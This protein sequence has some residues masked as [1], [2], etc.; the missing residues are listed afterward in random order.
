LKRDEYLAS[1]KVVAGPVPQPYL[2]DQTANARDQTGHLA[3]HRL[4]LDPEGRW[5][6]YAYEDLLKRDKLSLDLFGSAMLGR[7]DCAQAQD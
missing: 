4:L 7:S 1:V 2:P 3:A 6:C 5:R